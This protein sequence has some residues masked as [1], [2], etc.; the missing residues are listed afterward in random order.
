M[1]TSASSVLLRSLR[2]VRSLLVLAVL[3]GATAANAAPPDLPEVATETPGDPA[4]SNLLRDTM[5]MLNAQASAGHTQGTVILLQRVK[6]FG[7]PLHGE[8]GSWTAIAE[9]A[10][11]SAARG[12]FVAMKKACNDCHDA[13]R[14]SYR[15]K[16]G[17]K[18]GGSERNAA[19]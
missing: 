6:A 15:N 17:S 9:R 16:Y 4:A 18:S 10:R 13:H 2:S 14:D 8:F 1:P 12:D 19:D 11:A 3:G 7:T 5:R